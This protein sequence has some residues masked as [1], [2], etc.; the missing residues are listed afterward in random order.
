VIRAAT[1]NDC[2][3]VYQL[4]RQLSSHEFS[5][6]QFADCYHYNLNINHAV[7][8]EQDELVR[9][10][11]ILAIHYSLHFSR[12]SAEIV[13]LIV[14]AGARGHG[15][16]FELLSALEEIARQ[17]DCVCIEADSGKHREAAHRFYLREGFTCKHYKFTKELK[18]ATNL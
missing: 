10:F 9:G 2:E 12:K 5:K 13:N 7:V 4:M 14:D 8:F 11:G 1:K 17:N 6:E 3:A 16:G 15:I 18:N